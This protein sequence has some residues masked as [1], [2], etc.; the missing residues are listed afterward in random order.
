MERNYEEKKLNFWMKIISSIKGINHCK[1]AIRE[2]AGKAILYLLLFAL[3]FGAV[4]SIR[5]AV[6]TNREISK[7]INVYNTK[8][9]DFELVNGELTVEGNMPMTL[10]QNEDYYFVIDTT[11][12]TSPDV[13]NSY[14]QGILILKDKFIQKK[15]A[16]QTQTIEFSSLR[17]MTINKSKVNRYLPLAKL[18]IPFIFV[19][20]ILKYFLGGLISALILALFA[21]ILNSTFK[22]NLS[23]GQLYSLSIYALTVPIIMD[24]IFLIFNINHFPFYWLVYHGIAFAYIWYS[25]NKLK[26]SQSST[27]I[28]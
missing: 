21:L 16:L 7:F 8:C 19:G 25:L 1:E 22:T 6:D 3:I 24:V 2:T 4:G 23:Y 11:N 27:E 9:P 17:G 15:N 28:L 18:I 10:A 13:L 20:N 12:S 14:N 26:E 5:S